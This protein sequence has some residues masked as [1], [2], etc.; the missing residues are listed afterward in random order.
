MRMDELKRGLWGYK[1]DSVYHYIVSLEEKASERVAEKEAKLEQLQAEMKRQREDLEAH[2]K[3]QLADLEATVKALQVENAALREHQSAVFSTMLEAQ[4]Y[5]TQLK[6]DSTRQQ[7]QAEEKLTSA[8][9]KKNRQLGGYLEQVQQLR[10]MIQEMLKDFDVRLDEVERALTHLP[11]QAPSMGLSGSPPEISEL[12]RF[13]AS[14]DASAGAPP[15][16][17]PSD[18]G[19][20][21]SSTMFAASGLGELPKQPDKGEGD[22][23]K[24]IL[25]T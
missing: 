20:G 16:S 14:M 10:H 24:K 8:I 6:A 9:Q 3:R 25:F 11:T 2:N 7:Q 12:S 5:A 22:E 19:D 23:W 17:P 15:A 21:M 13:L 1:K 4:K 18:P